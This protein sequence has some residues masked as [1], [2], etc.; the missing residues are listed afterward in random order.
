MGGEA[1]VAAGVPQ[2]Q[3]ENL[4]LWKPPEESSALHSIHTVIFRCFLTWR[5]TGETSQKQH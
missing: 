2:I 4:L 1:T 3:E 5:H